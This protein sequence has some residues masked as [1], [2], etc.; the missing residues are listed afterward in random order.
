M[1]K[2][3]QDKLKEKNPAGVI[4]SVYV[5]HNETF[6]MPFAFVCYETKEGA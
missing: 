5:S 2:L 4:S 3:I 6:D 1:Q